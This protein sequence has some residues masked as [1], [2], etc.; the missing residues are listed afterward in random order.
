MYLDIQQH[1]QC[2]VYLPNRYCCMPKDVIMYYKLHK[3]KRHSLNSLDLR[4]T[5]DYNFSIS[6]TWNV[7]CRPTSYQNYTMCKKKLHNFK[8]CKKMAQVWIEHVKITQC[9]K[10]CEEKSCTMWSSFK[11]LLAYAKKI[12]HCAKFKNDFITL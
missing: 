11:K 1:Y 4:W 10:N 3:T 9:V 2:P 12:S 8:L 5:S 6:L 7:L